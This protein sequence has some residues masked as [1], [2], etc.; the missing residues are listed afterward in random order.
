MSNNGAIASRRHLSKQNRR[1]FEPHSKFPR[2]LSVVFR[3]RSEPHIHKA[4]ACCWVL[5][6]AVA[7][8]RVML[9]VITATNDV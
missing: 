5:A 9:S 3:V 6:R 8:Q 4:R 2:Q 7:G 1:K